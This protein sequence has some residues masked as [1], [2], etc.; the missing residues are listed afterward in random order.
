MSWV[1]D[2]LISIVNN[3]DI[4]LFDINTKNDQLLWSG[5]IAADIGCAISPNLTWV[6]EEIDNKNESHFL[7]IININK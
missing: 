1:N 7:Q 5:D 6:I 2:S 3:H 4:R